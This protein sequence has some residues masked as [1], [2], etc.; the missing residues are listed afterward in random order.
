MTMTGGYPH[1]A[2]MLMTTLPSG[3]ASFRVL[4]GKYGPL[5]ANGHHYQQ[6]PNWG[7]GDY[8]WGAVPLADHGTLNVIGVRVHPAGSCGLCFTLPGSYDARF[9]ASTLAYEGISAVPGLAGDSW[10]GGTGDGTGGW[11]LTSQHGELAHVAAGNLGSYASWRVTRGE[12]WSSCGSWPVRAGSHWDLFAEQF[13]GTSV[14]RWSA[15]TPAGWSGAPSAV[16]GI[17]TIPDADGGIAVHPE[18]PAP[19]GRVVISWLVNNAAYYGPEFG[20]ASL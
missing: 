13:G 9:N 8:F 12:P 7:N 1:G 19:A 20:Y 5:Q 2:F 11:W 3:A 4:Y 6:V 15:A 16:P 14:Q 18:F 17:T 10:S